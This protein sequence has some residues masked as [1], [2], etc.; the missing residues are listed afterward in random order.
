MKQ[1]TGTMIQRP[2]FV[3]VTNGNKEKV[4][5]RF[6]GEDF[7]FLPR[8]PVDIPI[9]VAAH[10]FD[11]GRE[12]KTRAL[13]RLG[14]LQSSDGLEKAMAKLKA[15]SFTEAPPLIEADMPEPEDDPAETRLPAHAGPTAP[16]VSP[17]SGSGGRGGGPRLPPPKPS[18]S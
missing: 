12:D 5:G 17:E 2:N 3:R 10:I 16:P 1:G 14:W 15:I 8:I 13:N 18:Q 6:D 4:T 9:V 7:E 11:F